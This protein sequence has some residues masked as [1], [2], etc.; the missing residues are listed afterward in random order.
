MIGQLAQLLAKEHGKGKGVATSLGNDNNDPVYPSNFTPPNTQ[1]QLDMH[2]Q[3]TL[4]TIR[5]QY[6][7]DTAL[8][9]HFP[10][11]SGSNPVDSPANPVVPDLD[12]MAEIDKAKMDLP[13]QLEDHCKW[14]EEKFKEM[15]TADYRYGV[16]ATDLSLVPDLV[17]PPKFKTPEFEKYNGTSCLEAHITM[18][19]RRMAGHINNYQLLI[20]CEM[21]E[22]AVQN[23]KIDAGE[24]VRRPASRKK[25][26]EVNNVN[27]YNKGYLKPV[28]VSQPRT[29]TTSQQDTPRQDSNPRPN[30]ER[31]QFTPIPMT[32]RELYQSLFDAHVVSP[33]YIKAMQPPFPKWVVEELIKIGVVEINDPSGP[34][35]TGN[36]LPN[37][38]DKGV[39]AVTGSGGKRIKV[40]LAEVKTPL[41]W[42]WKQMISKDLKNERSTR[43]KKDRLRRSM[44]P[45]A[46][47]KRV[48]WN[49]DCNVMISGEEN[50][51][52]TLK[53][54]QDVGFFTRSGMRYTLNTKAEP[55]K[56]KSVIVEQKKE[57]M[58]KP[59]APVNEPVTEKEANEF[60][61]VLKHSEYNVVE[62]L[63]KQPTRISI[64]A[65]LMSSETHRSALMKV[66]NETDAAGDISVNK[67]D[68]LVGNISSDNFIF[69]NNDEIPPGGM[70]STKALHIAIRCKGYTLP[71]VLVDNGSALNVLPLSTLNRLPVD[72][73]HMKMCQNIVRA[74]DGTERRVMGRIEIP[75]QIGPNTY[76]VDFLVM[77]IKPSYNC[78]L[79]RPWI[80]SAGAVSSSLHQKLKLVTEGRLVTI[81]AEEDIIASVTRNA[82]YIETDDEAIECSFRSI[83]FVNATFV[84]E[85]RK[86]P[87]PKISK[88]T[89]MSLQMI[90]GKGPN[91]K[92]ERKEIEKN[93]ERRKARLNG[94]EVKWDPMT[95]PHLSKTFDS[96]GTIYP[97]Q[98]MT[99]REV[100]EE[101]LGSLSI[102]AVSE[103]GTEGRDL[104]G[105]CPYAI[106]SVLNNWTMEEIPVTFRINSESLD[107]NDMSDAIINSESPFEQDMGEEK[108]LKIG[109]SI[110]T[111]TKRDLIMLLQEFKDVF[112]WSY[113]DMP[114]LNTDIVVHRLPIK[115]ELVKY[116]EWVANIVHVPK[117]DGKV[118]MCVDYRDLNKASPKDNFP[119]PYIDTLVDN[120]AGYSLFSFMDGFSGYNQI[121]MLPEDMEKTTF[122]T[123]WGTF[124]YK[125]MPFGLK[126]AGAT[127]QRAMVTL[128][129]DMMHKEIEVYVDD[130]IAKSRTEKEHVQILRKLFL[131]LRKFQL[132]LN[133]AKCT[134]GVRSG[135][136]LGFVVSEKGIEI[137]PDKVRAIQELSPPHTQKEVRGNTT[138]VY[139]MRSAR[140]LL[141]K[142]SITCP[143]PQC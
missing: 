111:E 61:K 64:L 95:F 98:R 6:Q 21:I 56:G 79:G 94:E 49:Y 113:Q 80:H 1:A 11:G 112:V 47:C 102:N 26:S 36:P 58:I 78:L 28:T 35:V 50:P 52:N 34:N 33:F 39:N 129:H 96:G 123:M 69:F 132:K 135:K 134:F 65:L 57:K 10:T 41:R 59:E 117:K 141:I 48:L 44:G 128:F 97:E 85:G 121:K 71:R 122:V 18:F 22:N 110:A 91:T 99:R 125:V 130:M 2:P 138:Q 30:R 133:P 12:E 124:C 115:E 68:R 46:L 77:D 107:I 87:M 24:S 100:A 104:S 70:G 119:L 23:R 31:I 127:Y 9:V 101:M 54:S 76:E 103:E 109:A 92:Q 7:T 53:E 142:S 143:K 81:N 16:D 120:T 42:V 20:H 19:C 60:L 40:D 13:R 51:A 106:G 73:S 118:R 89:R 75:L 84:I 137:D 67:L 32:Y 43:Q 86:I 62:Q 83:E 45:I 90:V 116:S 4:V 136:L 8:P 74:F 17:L 5:P 25:D 139:G 72:S 126:N 131:R 63:H 114:R 140:K 38:S 55:A 108:E 93:Q 14:L 3:G 105:I 37:H 66:L 27:M 88:S 82:P 15:E 29:I